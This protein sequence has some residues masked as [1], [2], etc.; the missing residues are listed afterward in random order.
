MLVDAENPGDRNVTKKEAKKILK[1]KDLR[2][3]IQLMWIVKAK[4][5]PVIRGATGTI[6]ISLRQYLS[7]I[8]GKQE[9]KEM[10]KKKKKK[11]PNCAQH[12]C[13]GTY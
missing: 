6:S 8:P 2:I 13:Y 3:Q 11:R 10:Q 4:V 1:Y 12:T 9:M 7:N 5:I